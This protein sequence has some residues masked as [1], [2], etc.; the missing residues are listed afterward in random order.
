MWTVCPNGWLQPQGGWY[1]DHGP[2]TA[3]FGA[4]S[5]DC[6]CSNCWHWCCGHPCRLVLWSC[7]IQP[8]SD[9]WIAFGM[10]KNY[11]LY[12]INSIVRVWGNPDHEPCQYSMLFLAVIRHLHS[13]EKGRNQCGE[14]GRLMMML[15]K[16][17][18][19]WPSIHLCCW[20]LTLTT[21]RSWRGWQSYCMTNGVLRSL[22]M[23]HAGYSFVMRA[24]QWKNCP[25]PKMLFPNMSGVQYIKQVSGQA[26][27]TLSKHFH[28]H[29]TMV[30]WRNQGHPRGYQFGWLF[31][32]CQGHA[33]NSFNVVKGHA[34]LANVPKQ[35][36][37]VHHCASV[38][39][40]Y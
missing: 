5:R 40:K 4:R 11:R 19:A 39:A 27:Q 23:K 18:F 16:H 12:H 31:L 24:G 3:R 35:I 33:G 13:T 34:P 20:T 2:H 7:H 36:Y 22:S 8:S 21:F 6:A 29:V 9:F 15:Q 17:S 37:H 10:G 25:L 14:L 38:N 30:G 32:R 28:L 26:V 1:E